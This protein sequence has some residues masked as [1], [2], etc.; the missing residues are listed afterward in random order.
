MK[1]RNLRFRI[2]AKFSIPV[3][4]TMNDEKEVEREQYANCMEEEVE[5]G[6]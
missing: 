2:I 5:A 3:V 6:K 1:K 4:D